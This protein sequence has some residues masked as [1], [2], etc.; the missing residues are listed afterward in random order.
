MAMACGRC[1]R[2]FPRVA[3]L[4]PAPGEGTERPRARDAVVSAVEALAAFAWRGGG[5]V[6]L[7]AG[8]T[9]E[10]TLVQGSSGGEASLGSMRT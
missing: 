2:S 10:H 1:R 9:E 4:A 6:A 5:S 7:V 8:R 3:V